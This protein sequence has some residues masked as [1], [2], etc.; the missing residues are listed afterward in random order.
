MCKSKIKRCDIFIFCFKYNFQVVLEKR[1]HDETL[2]SDI[3]QTKSERW[4]ALDWNLLFAKSNQYQ[5]WIHNIDFHY[6][7]SSTCI[8]LDGIEQMPSYS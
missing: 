7:A 5:M 8:E 3:L 1:V 4:V 6:L 2:A